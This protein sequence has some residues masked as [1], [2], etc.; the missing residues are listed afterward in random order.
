MVLFILLLLF[1][2]LAVTMAWF[3]ISHDRG[4]KEPVLALWQAAGLGFLGA[5]AGAIIESKLSLGSGLTPGGPHGSMFTSAIT[6]GLVEETCKFLPLALLIYKRRYFNELT[7]G[8][9]YFALAG[10]GFGLPEN[11]LYTLVFG[12]QAGM[13][14]LV[15]T[16]FF[17]AATTGMIGYFLVRQKL[18][19]KSPFV[20]VLPFMAAVVLHGLYD[21]GLASGIGYFQLVSLAITLGLSIGLFLLYQ[22]ATAEDLEQGRSSIGHNDFCR[23]CGFVNPQHHLYC[24]HCGQ[25]A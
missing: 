17:H 24:T 9:I 6:I 7:D 2:G 21:F 16:P 18:H 20:V 23:S 11:M 12:T 22:K 10:L 25:H 19:R 1:I 8:V 3:L 15:L 5:I 13:I 14:R 4:E